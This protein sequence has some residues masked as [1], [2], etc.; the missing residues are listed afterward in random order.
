MPPPPP[1]SYST[2]YQDIPHMKF[3]VGVFDEHFPW[4][5][6]GRR[7]EADRRCGS[8]QALPVCGGPPRAGAHPVWYRGQ[9]QEEALDRALHLQH[10]LQAQEQRREG[11]QARGEG[12][13]AL[14]PGS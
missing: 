11:W 1:D 5:V 4:R 8:P 9:A 14:A 13:P 2:D 3:A 6:A 7:Q 10:R 12:Q